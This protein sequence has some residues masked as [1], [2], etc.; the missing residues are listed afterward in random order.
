MRARIL[1]LP[2][3]IEDEI[4]GYI[5][6]KSLH[7][8]MLLDKYP[9]TKMGI[10]FKGF[11]KDQLDRV[12]RYGC[13]SKILDWDNG[14]YTDEDLKWD[15]PPLEVCLLIHLSATFPLNLY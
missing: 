8:T 7:L 13:V 14:Y 9:L 4:R 12:Y 3:E 11:T 15:K 1:Q 2:E 5:L 6:T 10:F